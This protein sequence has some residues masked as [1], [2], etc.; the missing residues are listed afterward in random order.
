MVKGHHFTPETEWKRTHKKKARKQS[1]PDL[2]EENYPYMNR[3]FCKYCGSRLQRIINKD[4]SI[5]WICN[6]LSRLGKAFC[7]G[8]RVPDEKLKPLS[9]LS[10]DFYIGK[11]LVHGKESYGY[12]RKPDKNNSNGQAENNGELEQYYVKDDHPGIVSREEWEAVQLELERRETFRQRHGVHTIG[13]SN[14]D[15]LYSRVFCGHC[16]GKMIRKNWR[17]NR[18]PFWKCEI[19]EKKNGHTCSSE[20]VKEADLKQAIVIAWNS[21]VEKRSEKVAAWQ[22]QAAEGNALE[23]YR[24]RLMLAVT[25]DG[26]LETEVP[27]LTR[28]F[29]EEIVVHTPTEM[30]VGFLDGSRVSVRL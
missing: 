13:S 23:R 2:N 25:D 24:A 16:G 18:A 29:L 30:T 3:I 5:T 22:R 19:A 11:E 26:P 10:G 14:N 6:G 4:G 27:E 20:N 12:S 9:N 17:G 1:V 8:I 21:L 7:K 15:P 28:M